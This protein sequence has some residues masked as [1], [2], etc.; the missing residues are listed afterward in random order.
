MGKQVAGVREL[1]SNNSNSN[2]NPISSVRFDS[3]RCYS[4]MQNSLT[5]KITTK[6]ICSCRSVSIHFPRSHIHFALILSAVNLLCLAIKSEIVHFSSR[7]DRPQTG[8]TTVID[9][10]DQTSIHSKRKTQRNVFSVHFLQSPANQSNGISWSIIYTM[11][12]SL[13]VHH[14][15]MLWFQ[16]W[17]CVRFNINILSGNQGKRQSHKHG[18]NKA[19]NK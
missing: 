16:I 8:K 2:L 19:Q 14:I 13:Y 17:K 12:E 4:E 9:V 18:T 10:S 3:V 5:L 15:K 11:F 7:L 6:S 1:V